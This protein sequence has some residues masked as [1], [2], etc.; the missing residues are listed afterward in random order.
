LFQ[1]SYLWNIRGLFTVIP[2]LEILD[3]SLLAI[4]LFV[5]T[6][7]LSLWATMRV[8]QVYGKFSKVS[9]GSGYTGAE[10]AA[11]ILRQEGIDDVEIAE[12]DQMLG[13]HYD[14]TH[15]RLV[16][17]SENF[18]GTSAAALGIAAHECGHAIQ[19]KQAYAPMQWRMASVGLTTF[20]S[21]IVL[22]LPLLGMFTGLLSTGVALILVAS[23]WG[24][25]MLFNLITLPVEFD[26]S[27]R[28]RT[29]LR[30][31]GLIRTEQEEAAVVKVLHAAAWTYVAAFITSLAYFLLHL[32]PLLGER[33]E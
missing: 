9:A 21:Q 30:Q 3:M 8:R 2:L 20:A 25:L 16:L 18:H 31:T 17:S 10:A 6:M 11:T 7:A 5:G 15:R 33:K 14:P 19:H 32:L 26:A 23:G 27:A 28:A 1:Y 4:L 24:I 13:D 22:W 29:V 12:H